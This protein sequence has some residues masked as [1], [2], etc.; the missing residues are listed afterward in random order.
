MKAIVTGVTGQDGFYL[1]RL[2]LDQGISVVGLSRDASAA[3][4][5]FA[6]VAG[7]LTLETFDYGAAGAFA[8]VLVRHEAE[9]IFNLA[10]KAT[11]VGM[12]DMPNEVCRLNGSFVLDVLEAI[13]HSPRGEAIRFCQASSSEMFGFVSTAPQ[14]ETTPMRPKS[15]YGAAKLYAHNLVRIYRDTYGLRC[16]SA[17]LYN[18]ESV[19]RSSQFVT[20]KIA[21]AAAA[22]RVGKQE[23]LTLD[24]LDGCRDWGYAPEFVDAMYKM[25]VAEAP[26]DYIVATGRLS[27]VRELCELAFEHV[28]LDYRQFVT[29][30][31]VNPRVADSVNLLGDPAKIASTLGWRSAFTVRDIMIELVNH[32]MYRMDTA[33]S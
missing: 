15:P 29:T 28:G 33:K 20:M 30:Q 16:C 8:E 18:H 14:T 27:S 23:V 32:E 6:N 26:D 5:M 10:A 24:S 25:A 4:V 3:R 9:L 13:R 12:F 2:L 7:P 21:R 1:T 22:I 31:A 11:G 17:I 19:R